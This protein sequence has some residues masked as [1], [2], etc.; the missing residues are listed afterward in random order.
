MSFASSHAFGVAEAIELA[1]AL[2]LAPKRIVVY[3]IEGVCF[4]AGAPFTPPVL[5]AAEEVAD[6]IARE[7]RHILSTASGTR[8][9]ARV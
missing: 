5:R 9:G 1:R 3:A 6:C 4:D 7:V 2:D 8:D